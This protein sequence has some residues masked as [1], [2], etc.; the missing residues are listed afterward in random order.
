MTECVELK[1]IILPAPWPRYLENYL[2]LR[3]MACDF[4]LVARK[5]IYNVVCSFFFIVY[6]ATG[7]DTANALPN[8]QADVTCQNICM[9]CSKEVSYSAGIMNL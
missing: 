7:A 4:I 3:G 8:N 2:V 1:L 6:V 9:Q 5:C